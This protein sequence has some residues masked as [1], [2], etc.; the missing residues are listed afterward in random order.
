MREPADDDVERSPNPKHDSPLVRWERRVAVGLLLIVV[1]TLAAQVIARYLFRSPIAWG[2]EVARLSLI[3]LTFVASGFVTADGDQIKVDLFSR[4]QSRRGRR[5]LDRVA[6]AIVLATC[7][8][9]LF[10]G[11]RFVYG[12]WPVGSP[13]IG[14]SMS[15]W[16]AAASFGLALM[17]WH[18]AVALFREEPPS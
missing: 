16:Y 4:R 11:L 15:L 9:L 1:G 13:G 12:V 5:R 17:A 8:L 2:E 10:G 7:L 18:T 3:W 6:A 14:V